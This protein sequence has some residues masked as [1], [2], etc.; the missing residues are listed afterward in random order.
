MV[1]DHPIWQRT[2]KR[3][4]GGA[5][6]EYAKPS[7]DESPRGPGCSPIYCNKCKEHQ[8]EDRSPFPTSDYFSCSS[9]ESSAGDECGH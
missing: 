6:R 5:W 7:T 9:L 1:P 2:R 4:H 8:E 3:H